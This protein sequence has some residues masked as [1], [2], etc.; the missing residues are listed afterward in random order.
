MSDAGNLPHLP[1]MIA[2][3]FTKSF[4][5]TGC[6]N[7][8]FWQARSP[9]VIFEAAWQMILD[10]LLLHDAHADEPRLQRTVEPFGKT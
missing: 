6:R 10:Y 9:E 1:L 2:E 7:R 8:Q 3:N 4:E 5:E